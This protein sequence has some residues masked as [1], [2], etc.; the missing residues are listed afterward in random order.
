VGKMIIRSRT[1][2]KFVNFWKSVSA[3]GLLFVIMLLARIVGAQCTLQFTAPEVLAWDLS[4]DMPNVVRVDLTMTLTPAEAIQFIDRAAYENKWLEH[5]GW[6][7]RFKG[8]VEE[9]GQV[10]G[11]AI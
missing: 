4:P 3:L 10:E 2:A 8:P 9:G 1:N 11:V 6:Y 5:E 7:A